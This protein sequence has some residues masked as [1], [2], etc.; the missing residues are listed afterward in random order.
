MPRGHEIC[1]E[2]RIQNETEENSSESWGARDRPGPRNYSC[3]LV[4][5]KLATLLLRARAQKLWT[6]ARAKQR[7]QKAIEEEKEWKKKRKKR[8]KERGKEE[9]L[10]RKEGEKV[11]EN[12]KKVSLNFPRI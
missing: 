4:S 3:Q 5:P 1:S 8:G 7:R 6:Q 10:R 9:E 2:L 11:G 12:V